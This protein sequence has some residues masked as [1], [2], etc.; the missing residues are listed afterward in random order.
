M[1]PYRSIVAWF[2][3]MSARTLD[4]A[5]WRA[6]LAVARCLLVMNAAE[7]V[8][9]RQGGAPGGAAHQEG[10]APGGAAR[11]DS[12]L[13][14][15]IAA[16]PDGEKEFAHELVNLVYA[17]SDDKSMRVLAHSV[18]YFRRHI[19]FPERLSADGRTVL[20]R[21]RPVWTD[22]DYCDNGVACHVHA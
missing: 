18:K 6:H 3:V 7:R 5:A 21:H 4:V 13:T 9:A 19:S 8:A 14:D 16:V 22:C 12:A 17:S 1:E 20:A 15:I 11:P 10:E 2:N